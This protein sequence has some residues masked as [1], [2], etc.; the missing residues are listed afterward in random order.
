MPRLHHQS[1]RFRLFS[2]QRSYHVKNTSSRPITEVKQHWARL[3]LG[4]ETAWEHW[5]LLSLL[6]FSPYFIHF[7]LSWVI[8][9][10]SPS[11]KVGMV[12]IFCNKFSSRGCK[13]SSLDAQGSET[14]V[15]HPFLEDFLLSLS[16]SLPLSGVIRI[17][18]PSIKIGKL[19]KFLDKIGS[20]G[21]KRSILNAPG[22][23]TLI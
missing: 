12:E 8:R 13:W 11:I 1:G 10:G 2:R 17:G 14:P 7:Q 21:C 9:K 16:A 23:E 22:T 5:V 20:T 15:S 4:W 6:L 19:E 3:V 18:L